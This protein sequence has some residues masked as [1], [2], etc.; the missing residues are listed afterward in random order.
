V[1]ASYKPRARRIRRDCGFGRRR[2]SSRC[3]TAQPG[4]HEAHSPAWRERDRRPSGP[5]K[6]AP[7]W[8]PQTPCGREQGTCLAPHTDLGRGPLRAVMTSTKGQILGLGSARAARQTD[9][10]APTTPFEPAPHLAFRHALECSLQA[11]AGSGTIKIA[12][13]AVA[14]SSTAVGWRS[15][16]R[17]ATA[18]GA[19]FHRTSKMAPHSAQDSRLSTSMDQ[20]SRTAQKRRN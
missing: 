20:L 2:E 16:A 4:D 3:R 19:S 17:S 5:C 14:R 12:A 9:D 11:A 18:P 7:T 15:R 8:G 13:W 6:V 10:L 1:R